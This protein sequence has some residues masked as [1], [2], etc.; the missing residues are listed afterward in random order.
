[1]TIAGTA[2]PMRPNVA[3][4]A[5]GAPNVAL[6]A[7]GAPKAVFGALDLDPPVGVG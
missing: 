3:F 2:G 7:L 4:G 5:L 6:G 1:M